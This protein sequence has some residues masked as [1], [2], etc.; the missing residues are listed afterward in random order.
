MIQQS[1]SGYIYKITEHKISKRYLHTHV[2]IVTIH[3]SQLVEAT[4]NRN[5]H[6]LRYEEIL[7]V[8]ELNFMLTRTDCGLPNIHCTYASVIKNKKRAH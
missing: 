7:A 2:H 1:T 6:I 3:N 5:F 8:H 4:N